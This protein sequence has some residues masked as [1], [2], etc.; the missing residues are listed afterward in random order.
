MSKQTNAM[1]MPMPMPMAMPMAMPMP[2]PM[3]MAMHMA[4]AGISICTIGLLS[5]SLDLL[6]KYNSHIHCSPWNY[7]QI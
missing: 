5:F 7:C 1:A 4:M 3:P 6:N 2:T